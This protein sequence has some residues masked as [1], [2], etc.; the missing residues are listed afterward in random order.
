MFGVAAVGAYAR[1]EDAALAFDGA[2]HSR[3]R[4][5]AEDDARGAIR[6]VN[7][8]GQQLRA[9]DECITRLSR[10]D[11]RVGERQAEEETG[12]GG[13]QIERGGFVRAE[14]GLDDAAGRGQD[15]IRRDGRTDQQIDLQ[16]ID[17]RAFNRLARG[18]DGEHR[19]VLALGRF[20]PLLD[21]GARSD[22]L[23]RRVHHLLQIGVR[24]HAL[25]ISSPRAKDAGIYVRHF[26]TSDLCQF[27]LARVCLGDP[28]LDVCACAALGKFFDDADGVANRARVRATMPDDDDALHA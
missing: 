3:A 13:S 5:V 16:R 12:A 10:L 22:P 26:L 6:V 20:V 28:A 23:I 15:L 14:F 18:A 2:E 19:S 21:A 24:Q 1:G 25:R 8:T 4:A 7:V 17:L 27:K 9:N 11:H